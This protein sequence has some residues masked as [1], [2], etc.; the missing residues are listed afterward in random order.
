MKKIVEFYGGG[1]HDC[2]VVASDVQRLEKEGKVSIEK[3]EVWDNEKNRK[4]MEDL[5][6][7]YDKECGGNFSVPSFYDEE[8]GRILCE[9]TT[10]KELNDWIFE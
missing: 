7:L 6:P 3:L 8:K 1:C 2:F 10:Y 9:P 5:K 4:R